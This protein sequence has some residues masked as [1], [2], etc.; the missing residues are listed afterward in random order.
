MAL[1]GGEPDEERAFHNYPSKALDELDG[2]IDG[3]AR[4]NEVVNDQD[5]LA[6]FNRICMDFYLVRP[7]LKGIFLADSLRGKLSG[8]SDGNKTN[9]Q[10]IGK[11]SAKDKSTAFNPCDH[12]NFHRFIAVVEGIDRFLKR[13]AVLKKGSY[14]AEH[15]PFNRP[16]GKCP[17]FAFEIHRFTFPCFGDCIFCT[18]R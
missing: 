4:S 9:P 2:C 17:D 16:M 5:A 3:A 6:F 18:Q 11:D 15:N 10:L 14:I 8:L 7:I 12:V 1:K 13:R